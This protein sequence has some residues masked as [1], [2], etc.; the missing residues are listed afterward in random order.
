MM[1][2][3]T[4]PTDARPTFVVD[5]GRAIKPTIAAVPVGDDRRGQLFDTRASRGRP[6]AD[7][8]RNRAQAPQPEHTPQGG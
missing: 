3:P 6:R 2:R 4:A 5:R 7:G 8:P 1:I